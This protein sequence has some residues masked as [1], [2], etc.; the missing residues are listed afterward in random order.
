[1]ERK[2]SASI[3]SVIRTLI[4]YVGMFNIEKQTKCEIVIRVAYKLLACSK[5][6]FAKMSAIFLSFAGSY[7]L[8]RSMWLC[9]RVVFYLN[10]SLR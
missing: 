10:K 1:M 7:L 2:A 4:I 8:P 6:E 3:L 9:L 5:Q